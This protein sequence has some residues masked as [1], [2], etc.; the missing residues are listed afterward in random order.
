LTTEDYKEL[1][2]SLPKEP[3]VYRYIDDQDRIIYVG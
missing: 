1:L 3:G 2:P